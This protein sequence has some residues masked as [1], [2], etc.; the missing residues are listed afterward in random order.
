VIGGLTLG[1]KVRSVICGGFRRVCSASEREAT[2]APAA[3]RFQGTSTPPQPR[4]LFDGDDDSM[5]FVETRD[6]DRNV[7]PSSPQR[8]RAVRVG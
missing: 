5:T 1:L 2:S 4:N 8:E 7:A 6:D 3:R